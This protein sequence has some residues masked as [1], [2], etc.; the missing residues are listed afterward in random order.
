[1]T[2]DTW[3]FVPYLRLWQDWLKPYRA[4]LFIALFMA[5]LVAGASGAYAKVIQLVVAA[6]QEMDPNV[7][8]WGPLLVIV[9]TGINGTAQYFKEV[10][11]NKVVTRMET[12]LRKQMF[13]TLVDADLARLQREPPAELATRFSADIGLVGNAVRGYVSGITN[14][15]TI[16]VAVIVMLTIDWSLTLALLAI[17]AVALV[18]VNLIGRKLRAISKKTQTQIGRMTS[19]VAEGLSGIRMARTYRLEK[20]LAAS[21]SAVFERLYELRLRQYIWRARVAPLMEVCIGLAVAVLLVVVAQRV[22]AGTTTIADFTGLLTGFGVISGPVRRIGGSYANLM[23]GRA[24]LDRIYALFDAENYVAGGP[25]EVQHVHGSVHFEDVSFAY[26]DGHVALENVTLTIPQG[27]KTAF[28]GRS[29]AGKTTVFNL[30]P[31]LYDPLSGSIS[32]DGIDLRDFTL[33]S[34]RDKI[35]VVSQET[36]LLSATVAENIGFGR[37]GA[38]REEIEAAARDAAAEEFIRALPEG[39]DTLIRP[40]EQSFSGGERQRISIARAMLRDAPILLLDEATSALD[41]ESEA[42]IQSALRRLA[43]GRTTMVIAHRLATVL[44]ADLIVVMDRARVVEMGRHD[45]LLA[46]KGLYAD[47]HGMQ[48]AGS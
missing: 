14:I 18:P 6:L 11:S 16:L 10:V 38:T 15:L 34:L 1:M 36:V 26:P 27:K 3:T 7:Y 44:D 31:R 45:E 23:Q 13:A 43:E 33:A 30:L 22:M 32:I 25:R 29:G 5:F 17:V 9:L 19:E 46:R 47:L 12:N 42:Q 39:F 41:A 24:A 35:A 20:P 2:Q 8:W 28:V 37:P 21:S 48:F 4:P 40:S